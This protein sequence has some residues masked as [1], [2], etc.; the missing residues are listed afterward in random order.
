MG[1]I[2]V[3][4]AVE[5]VTVGSDPVRRID[6]LAAEQPLEIRVAGAPLAVTM[7]TPGH[8]VE[9]AAGF[10][11]SEGVI[12]AAAEFR[13]AIHCGGPGAGGEINEYNVLDVALAP[14]V[15]PPSPDAARNFYTTSSCGLCGKASID[16]VRTVSRFDV[17]EDPVTVAPERIVALPD[18][19]RAGQA[20]F[21]KTGGLHAAGL[22]DGASGE[23]L[24]LR[25]DVGRHNA[26]DKVIGWA[27]LQ[28]RLPL[29]GAVLQV[30]GRASF[31]LV[32]KAVMAGIPVLSAVS[33]PSSLAAELADE[34]G[35]TLLGF[36]RGDHFNAYS[37][38]DR[39]RVAVPDG[40]SPA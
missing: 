36:V 40:P 5:K 33:A 2:T 21:D 19:L 34:A 25:E 23:L 17:R 39:V 10:L 38:A 9:L 26:V 12:G 22:F 7:R 4:R 27:L 8:D 16:A 15:R 30:S 11:V 29:R 1:R 24:V 14:G 37:R 28:E 31:E 3:R 18:R 13:S 32:Q 6:S 20:V 35:L